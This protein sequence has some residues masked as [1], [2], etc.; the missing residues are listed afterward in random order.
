MGKK[1]AP[2][3]LLA[4]IIV[5]FTAALF[6]DEI[7]AWWSAKNGDVATAPPVRLACPAGGYNSRYVEIPGEN[8][9]SA[10][11]PIPPGCDARVLG[12]ARKKIYM[13]TFPD[14]QIHALGTGVKKLHE[15][16]P[17]AIAFFSSEKTDVT[18]VFFPL[19][20]LER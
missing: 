1:K 7:S 4:L 2:S 19:G 12:D 17:D 15:N 8:K 9:E 14:G 16:N 20:T 3:L 11:V 6:K 13:K 10:K 5:V 18:V